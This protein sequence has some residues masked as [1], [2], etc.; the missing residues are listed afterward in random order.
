MGTRS[1][2]SIRCYGGAE[3]NRLLL[4]GGRGGFAGRRF[5]KVSK[6]SPG[7]QAGRAWLAPHEYGRGK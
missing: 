4:P 6:V 1:M 7:A 3:E 2:L 5:C